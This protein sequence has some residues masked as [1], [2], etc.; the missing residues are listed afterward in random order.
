MQRRK[1]I[2]PAVMAAAAAALTFGPAR[3]AHAVFVSSMEKL[4]EIDTT[5]PGTSVQQSW[6]WGD[7]F[8]SNV[9]DHAR[10][11]LYATDGSFSMHVHDPN[12]GFAWGTQ[13]LVNRFNE[14]SN[15]NETQGIARFD[16][17]VQTT[18]LLI[19]MTTPDAG[20]AYRS[21]FMA[22][23]YGGG[24]LDSYNSS[25][26]GH[27]YGVVAGAAGP[28]TQTYT[29][30]FGDQMRAGSGGQLWPGL[31]HFIILHIATNSPGGG[32]ADFHF[33][34]LRFVNV[35]T[36]VNPTWAAAAD[37]DWMNAASWANGVPNAQGARAI[38]YG[39]GT[40]AV[41]LNSNVTLG[42]LVLDAQVTSWE[43]I[44]D[45]APPPIVNYTVAGTGGITFDVATGAGEI[46][47]IAG[48]HAFN[49]PVTFS[50]DTRID[51][52]AGFG[53]D[54]GAPINPNPTPPPNLLG[55]TSTVPATSIS[56]GG[57]VTIASGVTLSTSGPGTV[58][59]A[60]GVNG[61]S[62]ALHVRGGTADFN[63]NATL[64]T[65]TVSPNATVTMNTGG[66]S[67]R[68]LNVATL[69]NAGTIDLK[70]NKLVTNTPVGT[71]T[72]DPGVGTYSG[73]Q[74]EVQRAY[75]FGAWDQ[76]GLTTS[77]PNA[78]QNAGVFSGTET[79]GVA[80]AEQVLFIGPTDTA[81]FQGQTVTGASTIAM[82]TYA[83]DLNFDG[84]VDGAD[85]GI[86]DN[87]VQFPG[88]D[89]YA[90]G[91]L[92]YD[93]VVD[94]ADYGI[95]DNTIQLQG[96]PFPGVT[97]GAASAGAD[98]TAVPEPVSIGVVGLAGAMG[99]LRRRR[100]HRH[101]RRA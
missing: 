77:M 39:A 69:A 78:G 50:D 26:L 88:T 43:H 72:G 51:T 21:A 47:V 100:R 68:V 49:V 58:S 25:S 46:F 96:A 74:G 10:S 22:I 40:G 62:G 65:L 60:G 45:A 37:G 63:A 1:A 18:K 92:N 6:T 75:N 80:T 38:F 71:Y 27:T 42:A 61:G 16:E 12:G 36:Q 11:P 13:Y 79:I 101:A 4:T 70:D 32:P 95:I 89:G 81:L 35:N 3:D 48:N 76:P 85:Y 15:P 86:I 54:T 17:V 29:W 87:N 97:F 7:S 84:L 2:Y 19:D 5:H 73:I 90:N 23:N 52:S 82:Y 9:V 31:S 33:D 56:L 53:P 41:A 28:R 59:F 93:G 83:G 30:D 66:G 8:D 14:P 91:D 20:P 44:D 34:N 55:R 99:M 94:G 57:P 64:A 24:F 98:L 67:N